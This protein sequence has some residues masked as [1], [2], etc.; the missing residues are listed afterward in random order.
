MQVG[1]YPSCEDSGDLIHLFLGNLIDSVLTKHGIS[2]QVQGENIRRYH[3]YLV[4]RV[5][6]YAQ[7]YSDPKHIDWVLEG[8]ERLK[9]KTIESGL[10]R[11]TAI[12]QEQIKALIKCDV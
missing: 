2:V 6:A 4:S 5:K 1:E 8:E 3:D 10:L 7:E 11:E 9:K 12:V